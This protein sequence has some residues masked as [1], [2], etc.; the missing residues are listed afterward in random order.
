[1]QC[2][3]RRRALL[4]ALISTPALLVPSSELSAPG[5]AI[6]VNMALAYLSRVAFKAPNEHGFDE[7][8]SQL[9]RDSGFSG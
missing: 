7:R 3:Q 9:A 2:D 4:G 1:M 5:R 6:T 8:S